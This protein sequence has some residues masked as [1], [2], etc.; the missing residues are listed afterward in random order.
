[1]K[2]EELETLGRQ[3]G[4]GIREEVQATRRGSGAKVTETEGEARTQMQEATKEVRQ[5]RTQDTKSKVQAVLA[6]KK[7]RREVELKD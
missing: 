1:M 7:Q 6:K 4:D 3:S 2:L 5:K